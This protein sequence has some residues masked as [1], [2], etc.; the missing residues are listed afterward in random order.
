[1]KDS[2]PPDLERLKSICSNIP[3]YIKKCQTNIIYSEA[4]LRNDFGDLPEERWKELVRY[5]R[6]FDRTKKEIINLY[7]NTI[8]FSIEE[9]LIISKNSM[10]LSQ[11]EERL[12]GQRILIEGQIPTLEYQIH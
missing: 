8:K 11:L 2:E 12:E 5:A 4:L 7:K 10:E 3:N 9:Q 6:L 1:M